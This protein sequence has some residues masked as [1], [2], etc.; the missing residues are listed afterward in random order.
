MAPS[1]GHIHMAYDYFLINGQPKL[2]IEA[3]KMMRY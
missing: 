1:N 2:K 3:K